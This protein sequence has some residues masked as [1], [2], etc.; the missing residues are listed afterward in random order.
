MII[1]QT[2]KL[3]RFMS[4]KHPTFFTLLGKAKHFV[5]HWDTKRS[6]H[7]KQNKIVFSKIFAKNLWEGGES[8]SGSG[9]SLEQTTTIS[10]QL[11]FFLKALGVKSVLDAGCGDL[12]WLHHM[13]LTLETYIGVDVVGALVARNREMYGNKK[14]S[15]LVRDITKDRLPKVELIF[16]R[17]C[18]GHFSFIDIHAA[19]RNFKRSKSTYLLTTTF[20]KHDLS[21]DIQTGYWRPLNLQL[22]PFNFPR[23][24]RLINEHCSEDDNAYTD[25]SLG[26]WRISELP[27][28]RSLWGFLKEQAAHCFRERNVLAAWA[29]LD[30]G[31]YEI[32]P[33]LP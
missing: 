17:D 4:S 13:D 10:D 7:D 26:L 33:F 18:L 19:V 9:S 28:S 27:G 6:L 29:I 21:V 16:C 5:R 30:D 8:E 3:K 31:L 23:P 25:K 2:R 14:R 24:I 1:S 11:P 15:F 12:N 32:I 20:P 22:P